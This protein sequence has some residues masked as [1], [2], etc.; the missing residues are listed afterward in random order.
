MDDGLAAVLTRYARRHEA[1]IAA[2]A[3]LGDDAEFDV[4]TIV[5]SSKPNRDGSAGS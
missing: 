5:P 3:G 1:T 2:A 4:V